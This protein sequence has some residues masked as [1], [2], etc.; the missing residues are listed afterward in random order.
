MITFAEVRSNF[1]IRQ[2]AVGELT[3]DCNDVFPTEFTPEEQCFANA[4]E[5]SEDH[6]TIGLLLCKGK[7]KIVAEYALRNTTIPM[8]IVEYPL[9]ESLPKERETSLLIIELI[10]RELGEIEE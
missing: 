5:V 10:E 1:L 4:A 3:S 7:N 6:S 2:Q 9:V 8:G